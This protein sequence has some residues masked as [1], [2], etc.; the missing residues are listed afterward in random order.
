MKYS[1]KHLTY[2]A[3][4]LIA[5][6]FLAAVS[7]P[8]ADTSLS[9]KAESFIKEASA[10][11]QGE[12]A[13]AQLAQQ[14]SQSPE[15]KSLAEMI[16]NDHQQSQEKL[17]TIAQTHGVTLDQGLTWSQK[18]EQGKLEKL[19]GSDFDQQ[20]AKA[21]LED[22]VNDLNKFQKAAEQLQEADVKQF[23]QENITAMQKHLQHAEMAAKAVGVDQAT[24][25]S[26]TSKAPAMGG[27]GENPES[28][29]GGM[30]GMQNGY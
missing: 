13:L 14:K 6:G 17:Q 22:H 24:I 8:A 9:R 27:T 3:S 28:G 15:I 10:G 16:Q 23:A 2:L 26:I 5:A 30:K 4:G 1:S 7:A 11:N 19:S 21:M 20:Y 25:S 12:I 18:R 29:R